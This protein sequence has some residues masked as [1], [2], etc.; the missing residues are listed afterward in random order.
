MVPLKSWGTVS[1]SHSIVTM[2]ISCII[3]EIKQDTDPLHSTPTLG[4]G[5]PCEYAIT[6][7][8]KKLE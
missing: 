4:T 5:Y 3:S 6:F 2:A 7:D 8:M 1:Y